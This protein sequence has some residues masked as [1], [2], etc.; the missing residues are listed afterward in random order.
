MLIATDDRFS[1][2]NLTGVKELITHKTSGNIQIFQTSINKE[3]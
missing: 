2:V 1:K 3:S